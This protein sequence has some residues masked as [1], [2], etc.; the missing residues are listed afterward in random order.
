MS[1]CDAISGKVAIGGTRSALKDVALD[2]E[3]IATIEEGWST[4]SDGSAVAGADGTD[5]GC[6]NS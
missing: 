5:I 1:D 4:G 6:E 2:F 3:A